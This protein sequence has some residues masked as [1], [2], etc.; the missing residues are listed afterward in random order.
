MIGSDS[1]S[2]WDLNL[3]LPYGGKIYSAMINTTSDE[4]RE[5]ISIDTISVGDVRSVM[6]EE[7]TTPE[8][9]KEQIRKENHL[10]FECLSPARASLEKGCRNDETQRIIHMHS[11]LYSAYCT[12]FFKLY[13]KATCL[14]R[15]NMFISL[16]VQTLSKSNG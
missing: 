10:I 11:I 15:V 7:R 8:W 4:C 1:A 14:V 16:D 9:R 13:S 12:Y 2:S 3:V 5:W 6:D